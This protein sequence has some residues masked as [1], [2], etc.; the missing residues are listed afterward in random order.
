M[1][2]LSQ[3][4]MK[5]YVQRP[6]GKGLTMTSYPPCNKSSLS[7]KP[8]TSMK[9]Y[10]GTLS[11]NHGLSFRI[12]HE[13]GVKRILAEDLRWH[14]IRLSIIPRFLG[15][16]TSQMKSN[17]GKLSESHDRSFRIRHVKQRAAPPGGGQT[18]TSYPVCNTTSLSRKPCLAAKTLLWIT[19]LKSWSPSNLYLK[20]QLL[21]MAW[22]ARIR[23]Q[24]YLFHLIQ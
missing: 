4:L 20:Q 23:Q 19:I 21:V 5:M 7:R 3:S 15:K 12:L 17:Y 22:V 2:A 18:M 14:H 11:G 16:H 24:I 10:Y 6:P 8:R 1:V 9:S 13:K